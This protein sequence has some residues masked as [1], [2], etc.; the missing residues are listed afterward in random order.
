MRIAVL[1]TCHNRVG[2][3]LSFLRSLV[4]I[5]RPVECRLDVFL[6]DDGSTD[7]TGE[8]VRAFAKTASSNIDIKVVEGSGNDFWCGGMRRAWREA[9]ASDRDYDFFLWANDDVELYPDALMELLQAAHRG[10]GISLGVVCGCFCDPDSGEFTYGGRDE[11]RLLLPNG[12]PQKCRYIH[13]NT[14]LVPR[15][16]FEKIGMF[17]SRW[18]HGF[19]DTDYGLMCIK[20]GL[21]CL[22]TT[23]YIGTC[24][25]HKIKAPWFSSKV[26]FCKRW[27]LM[28]RPVGGSFR[29]FVMFRRKHYPFRWPIDAVKFFVQVLFPK[30]FEWFRR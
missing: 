12:N 29:E 3:T 9:I 7:G 19:G 26:P 30:P 25:Q 24:S 1:L 23:K 28:W 4:R 10:S 13:G 15:S 11:R 5:E 2:K 14:V 17:D 16:T 20:A 21:T 22:T 27:E 8:Q 6:T 18:T